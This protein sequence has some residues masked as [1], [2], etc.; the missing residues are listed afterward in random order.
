MSKGDQ[1]FDGARVQLAA[2]ISALG[3]SMSEDAQQQAMAFL[4]LLD[5]WSAAYNLTAIT[6]L[7]KMVSHHLLDS[8]AVAPWLSGERIIDVGTGAGFP[9]VPLAL[10]YPQKTF[11]LLDSNGKKTRFITQVKASLSLKNITVV[12]SRVETYQTEHAF[13]AIIFRAV[14]GIPEMV[15]KTQHLCRHGGDFLAMTRAAPLQDF[16]AFTQEAIV[17]NVPGVEAERHVVRIRRNKT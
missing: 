3:L 8:L 9:G 10:F 1:D 5:K 7:R 11:V 12:Q 14:K 2:G 4:A 13:D 16:P 15:R 6:D 17:L